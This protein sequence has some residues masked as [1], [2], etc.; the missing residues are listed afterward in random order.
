MFPDP[1][2]DARATT[3]PGS[4]LNDNVLHQSIVLLFSKLVIRLV[5]Q[6]PSSG[7]ER[8]TRS[9]VDETSR[10]FTVHYVVISL[11]YFTCLRTYLRDPHWEMLTAWELSST[12]LWS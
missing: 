12:E 6:C 1:G 10:M 5:S 11:V 7:R 3:G 4:D 2:K 9:S 8:E